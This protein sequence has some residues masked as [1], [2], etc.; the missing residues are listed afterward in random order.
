MKDKI[1][2]TIAY[3]I[4][5][6]TYLYLFIIFFGLYIIISSITNYIV[7]KQLTISKLDTN[8]TELIQIKEKELKPLKDKENKLTQEFNALKLEIIPKENCIN[9]LK[10]SIGTM[11]D[12]SCETSF[13]PK[14]NADYYK[15]EIAI[16]T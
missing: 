9:K 11:E 8:K 13:I 6:K 10:K 16:F 2:L 12:I 15:P 14:A 7:N 5:K 4:S 3:L 1:L